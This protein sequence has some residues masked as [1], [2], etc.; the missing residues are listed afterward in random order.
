MLNVDPSGYTSF[1]DTVALTG[2]FCA[3]LLV[4]SFA[5]GPTW[6]VTVELAH[7]GVGVDSSHT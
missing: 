3:V 6:I 1:V 5:F 7:A 2:V 4:S